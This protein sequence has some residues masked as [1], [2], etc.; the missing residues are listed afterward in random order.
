MSLTNMAQALPACVHVQLH[1]GVCEFSQ[2]PMGLS[3]YTSMFT[4]QFVATALPAL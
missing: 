2:M 1:V 3:V 4:G